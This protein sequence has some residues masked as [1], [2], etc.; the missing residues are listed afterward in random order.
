MGK[1]YY[2]TLGVA[3]TA[4]EEEIK[5]AYKKQ[6]LKWHPDRN[7]DNKKVAEEKFKEIGEAYEVLSDKQK[8]EIYD[9]YGEEGLKGG[10]PPEGFSGQ[11]FPQ[12]F[13]FNNGG[14]G[15]NFRYNPSSANDIFEQFFRSMGGMG[16][17]GGKTRMGGMPGFGFSGFGDDSDEDMFG[18]GGFGGRAEKKSAPSQFDLP[19]TLEQLYTG[20]TRKMKV[21]RK[22]FD[23]SGHSIPVEKVLTIEVKPGWKASTK[24]TFEKEGDERP[25]EQPADIVFVVKELPHEKFKRDGSDLHYTAK[26][27]LKDALTNPIV[28]IPTLEG[29]KLK[30]SMNGVVS[31]SSVHILDGY[32]MPVSKHPGKKGN[33]IVHFE[34]QFPTILSQQQKE[35]IQKALP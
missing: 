3:K 14:G 29:K 11:G 13:S 22:V 20:C 10:V 18:H 17:M 23:G 7:P 24:I 27:S 1:D 12:G 33:L 2:V 30:V 28:E 35:L 9:K 19:C 31:P 21:T 6:A 15:G 16:G 26:L 25:G 4:T 8:R 32:G 34:V 5:K